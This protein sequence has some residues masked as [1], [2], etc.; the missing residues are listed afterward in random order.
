MWNF[1][2]AFSAFWPDILFYFPKE[3]GLF[4]YMLAKCMIRFKG[5]K[6]CESVLLH[7]PSM[8]HPWPQK[9]HTHTKVTLDVTLYKKCTLGYQA[10]D[11]F[12][13][14]VV[15]LTLL[16]CDHKPRYSSKI[17][18]TFSETFHS[19]KSGYFCLGKSSSL[20]TPI[21]ICINWNSYIPVKF[22]CLRYR[23]KR[24]F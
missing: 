22:K 3:T 12:I 20:A 9:M 2:P 7:F 5:A 16:A 17:R 1:I 18:N 10:I 8:R 21:I 6:A 4:Q 13:G 19:C 24:K 14:T 23:L 15:I 11:F